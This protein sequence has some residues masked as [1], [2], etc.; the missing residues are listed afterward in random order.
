MAKIKVSLTLEEELLRAVDR[1]ASHSAKNRSVFVE[2]ILRSWLRQRRRM[3]LHEEIASYYLKRSTAEQKEDHD[4]A[5][6]GELS[7]AE[8]WDDD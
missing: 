6:V 3:V 8:V 2:T 4:W 1:E 7:V 5:N